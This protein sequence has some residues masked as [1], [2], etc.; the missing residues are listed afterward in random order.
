VVRTLNTEIEGPGLQGIFHKLSQFTQF[1]RGTRVSSELGKVTAIQF[2]T[3]LL[4]IRQPF[5][6]YKLGSLQLLAYVR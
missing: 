4:V 1:E 6:C 3:W 2:L 5:A